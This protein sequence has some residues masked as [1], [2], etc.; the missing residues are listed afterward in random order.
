MKATL[1]NGL[2]R[3][4][5]VIFAY[6]GASLAAGVVATIGLAIPVLLAKAGVGEILGT[7][8]MALIFAILAAGLFFA[9][10]AVPALA[11]ILAAEF[12]RL[13]TPVYF[14]I[15]GAVIGALVYA[16]LT[17]LGPRTGAPPASATELVLAIVAGIA[18]G[19][20]YRL[21]AVRG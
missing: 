11:A 20:V 18:G 13:T 9:L 8:A 3:S 15:A 19:L 7:L 16:L 1:L 21:M 5:V 2:K 14:G 12:L 4:L 10:A 6:G 17:D